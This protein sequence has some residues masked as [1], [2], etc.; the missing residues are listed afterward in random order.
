MNIRAAASGDYHAAVGAVLVARQEASHFAE[1]NP[2]HF[3]L[4]RAIDDNPAA[5]DNIAHYQ[6]SF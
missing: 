6:P 4:S 1:A 3:A 5:A 2:H